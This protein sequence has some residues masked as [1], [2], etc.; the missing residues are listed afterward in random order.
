MSRVAL[1]LSFPH[2]VKFSAPALRASGAGYLC[3]NWIGLSCVFWG[4]SDVDSTPGFRFLAAR[5]IIIL[6]SCKTQNTFRHYSQFPGGRIAPL[7][8]SAEWNRDDGFWFIFL[9]ET[10]QVSF[11]KNGKCFSNRLKQLQEFWATNASYKY[12]L[13]EHDWGFHAVR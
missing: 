5:S 11:S 13:G 9:L 2:L 8:Q 10:R 1:E 6:F 7:P 4:T 3:V 12:I